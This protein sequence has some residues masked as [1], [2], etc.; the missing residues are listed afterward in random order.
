MKLAVY[1]IETLSNL[2]TFCFLDLESNKK[3]EFVLYDSD[4]TDTIEPLYKFLS[5]LIKHKYH[6]VGFN[7]IDFDAQ[8]LEFVLD[9]YD[10]WNMNRES[11]STIISAIYNKAQSIIN[12]PDD[13]R[14]KTLKPEYKLAI[15]QIDLFKQKHY[16]RPA[17]A[18][19]LKWLQFTMRY[20]HVED[21]P[22]PHGTVVSQED[23]AQVL[24]YNWNDVD[25]TAAFFNKIRFE[26]D[27]RVT[28]SEKYKQNLLNAAEPK[29]AR[30]IFAGLLAQR[31][32]IPV[33]S[34]RDM[35]T[36]RSTIALK[37]LILPSIK[38]KNKSCLKLLDKIK[39]EVV[40]VNEKSEVDNHLIFAG[41]DVVA[42]VG[43]IHGCIKPGRYKSEGDWIIHDIDI[44]SFYPNLAIENKLK[45]A[46]LNEAFTE[47][48]KNIFEERKKIP[49]TDPINYVYKIILN[50][51]FGL[52]KQ[53]DNY[54]YD[55]L[56]TYSIT[57]NGQLVILMLVE[58]FL[59]RVPGAVFYQM[60]TD[61]ITIGYKKEHTPILTKICEG[62]Y[63]YFK[64]S[65]EHAYYK[66]I[67]IRD[68][69]NYFASYLDEK[70]EPKKKGIFETNFT[71]AGK[72]AIDYH[73]NPTFNVIALAI[74]AFILHA[75]PFDEFIRNHRDVFDFFGGL[76]KKSNFELNLYSL[77][78]DVARVEPQ[79]KVTR[80]YVAKKGG[81]LLK[82]FNDGRRTAVHKDNELCIANTV[83][84]TTIPI[85]WDNINY[86]YYIRVE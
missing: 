18:T 6:L 42:G 86:N 50:S 21:M 2:I 67:V 59:E 72:Q 23:I 73:K 7:N 61:G 30:N 34:L 80:F 8:I 37:D 74:E 78:N 32:D 15:P 71:W 25:S 19:S 64:L 58:Q 60:N 75:T 11:I 12:L 28:L 84:E 38:F 48:Y 31:M 57:V 22:I 20:P 14:F 16:N 3:R 66:E 55:P 45:P 1:D 83:D 81:K 35:R 41:M 5:S 44:V 29:L 39:A 63:N 4:T 10:D 47:I 27:L 82:E 43:G 68:V 52:S 51:T 65:L 69:N 76:K 24:K 26:T 40:N 53:P 9:N 46:H 13:T 49:K 36:H 77:V 62:F 33:N 85:I 54:L 70:K 79:H 56:F 17:K